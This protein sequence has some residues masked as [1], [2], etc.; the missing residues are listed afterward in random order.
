MWWSVFRGVDVDLQKVIAQNVESLFLCCKQNE[1]CLMAWAV[2]VLFDKMRPLFCV[3]R[4]NIFT[5]VTLQ[6]VLR[7][8]HFDTMRG[9]L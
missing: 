1:M 7:G 5:W 4:M 2:Y 9:Q 8:Y 3:K 6:G